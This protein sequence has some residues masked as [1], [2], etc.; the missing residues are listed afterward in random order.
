MNTQVTEI[1]VKKS[2]NTILAALLLASMTLSPVWSADKLPVEKAG[3]IGQPTGKIAFIRE[4][5]VWMM[6]VTGAKQEKVVSAQNVDGRLSWSPDNKMIAFTRTGMVD[7]K[8]PDGMGGRHKLNDI[9]ITYT[10]STHKANLNWMR[11][12]DDLGSRDPE[13]SHDGESILFWKDIN[14]NQVNAAYPNYQL[15][16]MDPETYTPRPLRKDWQNFY[17]EF[18]IAPSMGP[19]GTIA[20]VSMFQQKQQG[21]VV[22]KPE[23]YMLSLDSVK[24]RALKHA[25]LVGPSI[26]P[27]GKWLAY[28]S[29]DLN[30]AGLYISTL[31]FKETYLVQSPPVGTYLYT[32]A[33]SWSSDSKWLTFSTTDGSVWIVDITG[34]NARRVTGPGLDKAPAWSK[35]TGSN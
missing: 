14:A 29:N 31:D 32:Y 11:I 23:E 17:D 6:D 33:P 7:L 8:G 12:T 16:L 15:M 34:N 20:A 18:L 19:N 35:A 3:S 4:G 2:V 1:I 10:D 30:D 25:N 5:D 22:L 21:L 9:F 28:I 27:D 26:S 13:W 24:A